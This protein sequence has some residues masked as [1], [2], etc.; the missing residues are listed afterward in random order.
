MPA[1]V[2][3]NQNHTHTRQDIETVRRWFACITFEGGFATIFITFTGSAFLPGLALLWGANDFEIG[4]L[5]VVRI[6][7]S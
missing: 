6:R 2:K 4:L 3:K 1:L 7:V 5:A